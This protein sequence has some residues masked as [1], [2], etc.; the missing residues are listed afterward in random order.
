MNNNCR[1]CSKQY[2]CN[3][4]KCTGLI[5][6]RELKDY[7]EVKKVISQKKKEN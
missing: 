6:Y 4:E 7:G 1:I 5:R 2:I 3:K